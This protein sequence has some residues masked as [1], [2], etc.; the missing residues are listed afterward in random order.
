MLQRD[1]INI[2]RLIEWIT[3]NADYGDIT[4]LCEKLKVPVDW[5][6]QF[7]EWEEEMKDESETFREFFRERFGD[8][9]VP[10]P[11][12]YMIKCIPRV[13]AVEILDNATSGVKKKY[14]VFNRGSEGM[15]NGTIFL[16]ESE[17][18]LINKV[19]DME[20]WDTIIGEDLFDGKT[21]VELYKED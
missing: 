20:N 5:F 2:R 17:A 10:D 19:S 14:H 21:Y 3:N 9:D 12:E 11:L 7:Y 4:E 8:E 1:E 13:K 18:E 16:T 6:E 15:S